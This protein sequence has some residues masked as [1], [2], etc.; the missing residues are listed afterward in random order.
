MCK[1]VLAMAAPVEPSKIAPFSAADF[2]GGGWRVLLFLPGKRAVVEQ[3]RSEQLRAAGRVGAV[4]LFPL[5]LAV[6]MVIGSSNAEGDVRGITYP[7]VAICAVLVVLGM[8]ALMRSV[9]RVREGVR[10]DFDAARVIGFPE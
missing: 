8:L 2:F 4:L 9:R 10:L 5:L 1:C 6:V 7:L 3:A